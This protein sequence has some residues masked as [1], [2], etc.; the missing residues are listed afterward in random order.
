MR[1]SMLVKGSFVLTTTLS[2]TLA[3]G[4]ASVPAKGGF[5]EVQRMVGQRTGLSVHWDQVI[6]EDQAVKDRIQSLVQEPLTAGA[7]VQ[8]ALL[9]NHALQATYEE[10]GIAQADLVQ[11]GLLQNPVFLG[12][13]RSSSH[14]SVLNS[15]YA[16][17][18]NF[19]DIFLLPLRKK[20]A[21]AQFEQAKLRVSDAVLGFSV[22][23]RTAY[24]T[25][26]GAEHVHAMRQT[27]MQAAEA[28]RE[29]AER[30]HKAGNINDLELATQQGAFQQ[31]KLELAQSDVAVQLARERLHQ[32]LGFAEAPITW[33]V[34]DQLPALPAADPALDDLEPLALSQRLDLAAARKSLDILRRARTV[35]RLGIVPAVTVGVDTEHDLDHAWV[36]GPTVD[37]EAPIFDQRQAVRARANAQLRQ[38]TQ[39]LSALEAE[40]RSEVRADI[41]R[42]KAA[43]QTAELYRDHL[44]PIRERIVAETQKHVNY[45]LLGVFQLLQAKRDEVNASREYLEALRDYWIAVAELERAV[46]GRLPLPEE[47]AASSAVQSPEQEVPGTPQQHHHGG[48]TP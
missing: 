20:L 35:T 37:I 18:Q 8:I 32:L 38:A 1:I 27:V 7:A 41:T 6:P 31:A 30:Q 24:Y 10:L 42:L 14:T 5:A 21:A 16:L 3:A 45:M 17:A 43:R 19:L 13:W 22:Q 29:L 33:R 40:T 48:E 9:N 12:S 44:I 25:L 4:C 15:E 23:V 2:A 47:G 39:R 46:G 11:A 36:T 26:Q 28:A 34:V